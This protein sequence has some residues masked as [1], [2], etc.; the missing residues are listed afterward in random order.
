MPKAPALSSAAKKMSGLM[1]ATARGGRR[2]RA[3]ADRSCDLD[4]WRVPVLASACAKSASL[5]KSFSLL[6]ERGGLVG[7]LCWGEGGLVSG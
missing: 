7:V 6:G 1:S 3:Y 2:M 4:R 5:R